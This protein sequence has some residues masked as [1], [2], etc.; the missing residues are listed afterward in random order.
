M[1]LAELERETALA[2][3]EMETSNK[4]FLDTQD[5]E[6]YHERKKLEYSLQAKDLSYEIRA[7]EQTFNRLHMKLRSAKELEKLTLEEIKI[8]EL[9]EQ[10]PTFWQITAKCLDRLVEERNQEIDLSFTPNLKS[11]NVL[12]TLKGLVDIRMRG[13]TPEAVEVVEAQKTFNQILTD[14]C[15]EQI[16]G[17]GYNTTK[18]NQLKQPILALLDNPRIKSALSL[19]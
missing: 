7:K 5:K 16:R 9:K 2:Q 12:I 19:L 13:T 11:S 10:Q 6:V 17:N 18:H 1:K 8:T 15:R 4:K 14:L 3:A